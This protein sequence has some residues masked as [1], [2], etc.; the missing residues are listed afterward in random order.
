MHELDY[1]LVY[2][3]HGSYLALQQETEV[4]P[5]SDFWKEFR[6]GVAAVIAIPLTALSFLF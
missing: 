5:P 1:R 3:D 2:T 4:Q 6:H